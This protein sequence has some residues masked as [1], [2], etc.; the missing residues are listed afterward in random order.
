VESGDRIVSA[1]TGCDKSGTARLALKVDDHRGTRPWHA[2]R[3]GFLV[4]SKPMDVPSITRINST[5][6]T[7]SL[8]E[9]E[10]SAALQQGEALHREFR[11]NISGDYVAY[12][13]QM[14][15]EGAGIVQLVDDGEVRAIAVWR[16]FLTTYCGRRFEIDDLVTAD[17]QRSKGYGSTLIRA[18]EVQARLLGCDVVMLTSAT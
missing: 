8:L 2:A 4:R 17:S 3:L 12:L 13:S 10:L 18:L 1:P 7:L 14:A 5:G 15:G 9:A 16:T 6:V 11:P